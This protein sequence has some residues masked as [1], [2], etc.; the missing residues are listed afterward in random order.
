MVAGLPRVS[1]SQKAVTR[2]QLEFSGALSIEEMSKKRGAV[3][4]LSKD[5]VAHASSDEEP[6]QP[7][8]EF[9]QSGI[10]LASQEE[11]SKRKCVSLSIK[12]TR[13]TC[14]CLLSGDDRRLRCAAARACVVCSLDIGC[15]IV[16][17][18]GVKKPEA[19][20]SGL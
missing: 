8:A 15:R 5:S 16:K 19:P 13:R 18:I 17:L 12:R 2:E 4:Q 9:S 10:P 3:V 1:Y 14:C 6:E 7:P 20:V 11:L